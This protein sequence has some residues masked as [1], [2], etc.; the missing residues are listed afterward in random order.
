MHPVMVCRVSAADTSR[1]C[2]RLAPRAFTCAVFEAFAQDPYCAIQL[3]CLFCCST[4]FLT[5]IWLFIFHIDENDKWNAVVSYGMPIHNGQK[6][7]VACYVRNNAY[8]RYR[9]TQN[10]LLRNLCRQKSTK[11]TPTGIT[12]YRSSLVNT[13]LMR[14]TLNMKVKKSKNQSAFGEFISK[15]TM[16]HLGL[17][18]F[19]TT[20]DLF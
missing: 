9:V 18:V 4:V 17:P 20:L 6:Q 12:R 13:L 5:A 2:Q 1:S 3:S 19:G 11:Y 8:C 15:N 16:A 7:N 10:R 14:T